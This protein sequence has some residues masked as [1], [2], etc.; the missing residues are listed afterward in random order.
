MVKILSPQQ[1]RPN[2]KTSFTG[3]AGA[4]EIPHFHLYPHLVR[5]WMPRGQCVEIPAPGEKQKTP[6]YGTLH[7]RTNKISYQTGYGRNAVEFL[8]FLPQLPREYRDRHCILVLY[9]ASQ[10]YEAVKCCDVPIVFV[11]PTVSL[12]ASQ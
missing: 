5:M 8:G 7:Y 11:P 6:I 12:A 9:N 10:Y 2:P 4:K 3:L 1:T